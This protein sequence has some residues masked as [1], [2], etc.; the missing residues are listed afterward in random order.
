MTVAGPEALSPPAKI[1]RRRGFQ[2]NGIHLEQAPFRIH[3]EGVQHLPGDA[4]ADG[5]DD[6]I[7]VDGG[8]ILF[9]IKGGKPALFVE[10][11]G[12]G[13]EFNAR[14]GAVAENAPGTPAVADDNAF[15]QGGFDFFGW[16]GISSRCSREISST[17]AAPRRR[18]VLATSTATL[19]PPMTTTFLPTCSGNLSRP[20]VS[21]IQGRWRHRPCLPLRRP[22]SCRRKPRR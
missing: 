21:G 6:R 22:A 2:G 19:P 4:L 13:L 1:P 11:P 10:D 8:H 17:L 14:N 5:D 9:I 16:A 7:G 12:T 3:A 18:A 15:S 20:P